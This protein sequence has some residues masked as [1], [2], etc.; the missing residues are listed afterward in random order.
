MKTK[1]WMIG[2]IILAV[3]ASIFTLYHQQRIRVWSQRLDEWQ[4]AVKERDSVITEL[5]EQVK[6]RQAKPTPAPARS[7]VSL[8]DALYMAKEFV[9]KQLNYPESAKFPMFQVD[10]KTLGNNRFWV[11]GKVD[12]K[13]ALGAELRYKYTVELHY[14]NGYWYADSVDIQP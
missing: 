3:Y 8:G 5:Q 7:D 11:E 2:C 14:D 12:A 4:Q 10:G 1:F 13:N 9:K 6:K